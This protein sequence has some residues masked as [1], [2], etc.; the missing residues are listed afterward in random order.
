VRCRGAKD[1]IG[2]LSGGNQQKILL[3]R[4]YLGDP[5]FVVLDE[6][7]RGIDIGARN[8]IYEQIRR[9]AA[10]GTTTIVIS[11][12]PEEI[13]ALADRAVVMQRGEIVSELPR[14]TREEVYEATVS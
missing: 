5:D 3:A 10:D 2:Q 6:P 7:T 14:P 8:E 1:P 4:A 13:A 11:N 9:R 12:E